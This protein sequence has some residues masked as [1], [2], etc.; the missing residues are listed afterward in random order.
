MRRLV[1]G[2]YYHMSL[3]TVPLFLSDF[4]LKL[5]LLDRVSKNTQTSDFTYVLP[6][7]AYLFH[8]D[9]QTDGQ[10]GRQEGRKAGRQKGRK[11]DMKT[12][13]VAFRYFTSAPMKE[14]AAG[15]MTRPIYVL[16]DMW[17]SE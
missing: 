15:L 16:L 9:R 5:T 4:K 6:V 10:A 1:S 12:L 11:A 8:E 14:R 17:N 13:T 3:C 2:I 7:G